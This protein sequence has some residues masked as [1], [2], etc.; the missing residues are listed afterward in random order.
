MV[1][2]DQ[3]Q[4]TRQR[5]LLPG[6]IY[7]NNKCSIF[8]CTITQLSSAGARLK[9]TSTFGVPD[10]FELDIP[11]HGQRFYCRVVWSN[12]KEMGVSF[13]LLPSSGKPDLKVV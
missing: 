5:V 3:R 11:N 10:L 9:L 8:D 4:N 13:N 12:M 7:F 2:Q 6:K 1:A